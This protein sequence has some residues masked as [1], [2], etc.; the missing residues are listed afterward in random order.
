[1][2]KPDQIPLAPHEERALIEA[3]AANPSAP[4]LTPAAAGSAKQPL[5]I[6]Q[7]NT[8]LAHALDSALPATFFVQGEISNFKTYNRGHAFFTMKDAAAELPC[9]MWKD[10]LERLKFK[11]K[12][13]L[14]VIA[15]GSV[16]LYEPQGKVQLYVESMLPVGAGS[17]ELA[18]RQLCD[19]LKREGLFEHGR[20]R[21]IPKLPQHIALITSRTGDVL[22]DVLTTAWRRY[23]GLRISLFPVRVQGDGAADDICKSISLLNTH[24]QKSKIDLILLVRG[25]GSLED[26]WAFNEERLAR[27]IVAS[28]IPIATG[29]GHEPDTT[30]ADLVGDLRG[31]TPT[32]IAELTIPDARNLCEQLDAAVA[33]M[34]RDIRRLLEFWH[35]RTD[36][37]ATAMRSV[38][39]D[40]LRQR[41]YSLDERAR[42]IAGIEPKHAIAQGWRRVE[43]AQRRLLLAASTREARRKD[44][45]ARICHRL[46]RVSPGATLVRHADHLAHL[47]LRLAAAMRERVAT[48]LQ[49]LAKVQG[50]LRVVS[51]QAVLERGFSITTN[52]DGKI[53]RSVGQVQRGDLLKT[54][55]SDGEIQSTVG[56]PRQGTLF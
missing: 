6:S 55:V 15:K 16:R 20:K 36:R 14:A 4:P 22:H 34:G 17:L 56:K 27:A 42:I 7:T 23:P 39:L 40:A 30:I 11:P 9:M 35:A 29:I 5:T 13:G 25:G 26:L 31:P 49:R 8:L 41:R 18:F 51:P 1:Q 54:R 24:N 53:I 2:R 44:A 47:Q 33:M 28:L 3:H 45:F 10:N 37:I 19:K 50:E 46:D 48:S 38:T 52:R 12:D 21:P 32:G 43:D